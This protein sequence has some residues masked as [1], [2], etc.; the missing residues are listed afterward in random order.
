MTLK[1]FCHGDLQIKNLSEVLLKYFE[2]KKLEMENHF[3]VKKFHKWPEGNYYSMIL[4]LLFET[5]FVE[6][7]IIDIPINP[8]QR[9]YDNGDGASDQ[10]AYKKLIRKLLYLSHTRPDIAC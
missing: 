6:I 7:Q 10:G 9:L 1:F 2:M 5:A 8:N 3:L 4:Y